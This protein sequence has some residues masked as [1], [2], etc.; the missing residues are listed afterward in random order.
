VIRFH[1]LRHT[2]ASLALAADVPMK[3][4]SDRLGHSTTAITEN[5][6]A[7]VLPVVARD[8]ANR[9]ADVV[10]HVR[11]VARGEAV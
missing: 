6:Y 10:P 7:K 3:V 5:L 1:D 4:V 8:A 11:V 2:C 9:I